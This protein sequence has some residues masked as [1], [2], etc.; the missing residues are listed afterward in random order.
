MKYSLMLI[1]LNLLDSDFH[2]LLVILKVILIA[3]INNYL[4]SFVSEKQIDGI[5][6]Y[7]FK[8]NRIIL[9]SKR[10]RSSI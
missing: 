3:L 5:F 10:C 8:I 2:R 6:M 7:F 1:Y 9:S 4:E